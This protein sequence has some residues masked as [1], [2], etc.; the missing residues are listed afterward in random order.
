[1][2]KTLSGRNP[3]QNETELG[4]F[5]DLLR[6]AGVRSYCEI[7][8]RHGDTFYEIMAALPRGSRGLAVDL[9]GALWG[10]P[11]T[12]RALD[13]ACAVLRG[14]GYRAQSLYTDS[15]T[16]L[17]EDAIY[18]SGP[19][20]AVL[21][22]GD[23][24]YD[25]VRTDWMRYANLAPIVAFHDIVGEGQAERRSGKPVEVPRLWA[26]IK[27]SGLT[28]TQFVAEGSTMGIGVVWPRREAA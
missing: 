8:A 10:A 15:Q 27:A 28:T 26:E 18:A 11:G 22:D 3:S 17:A 24:T 6:R 9:P 2:L 7:G 1:M 25:G 5:I 4:Q 12:E 21:I 19:F 23:H 13:H 20:D 16:K 14:L